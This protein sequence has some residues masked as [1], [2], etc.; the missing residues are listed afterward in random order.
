MPTGYIPRVQ[1]LTL[2][3]G[4]HTS[5]VVEPVVDQVATKHGQVRG[6]L[7]GIDLVNHGMPQALVAFQN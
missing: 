6:W 4:L 7:D 3:Q 1:P 5:P 2:Q